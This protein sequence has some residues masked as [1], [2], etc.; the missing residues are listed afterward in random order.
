VRTN[1]ISLKNETFG[2]VDFVTD[3]TGY[4]GD[5]TFAPGGL[6]RFID[7]SARFVVTEVDFA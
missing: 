3:L 2:N 7:E 4:V 1:Q 5:E 6:Q